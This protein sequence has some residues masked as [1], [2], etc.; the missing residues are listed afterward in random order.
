MDAFE[1]FDL[2]DDCPD[3]CSLVTIPEPSSASCIH[4]APS[5]QDIPLEF[6]HSASSSGHFFCV[7]A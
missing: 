4:D 5:S 7:I 3:G 6:E 1:L 2:F